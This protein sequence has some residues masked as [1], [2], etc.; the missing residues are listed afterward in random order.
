MLMSKPLVMMTTPELTL[1]TVGVEPDA[2]TN[3]SISTSSDRGLNHCTES[4]IDPAMQPQENPH[5]SGTNRPRMRC[6]TKVEDTVEEEETSEKMNKVV[7]MSTTITP[8]ESAGNKEW[9]NGREQRSRVQCRQRT[10]HTH[11]G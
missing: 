10:H 6:S 11:G 1:L 9:Y 4:G 7:R 2:A 5:N 3:V 8:K